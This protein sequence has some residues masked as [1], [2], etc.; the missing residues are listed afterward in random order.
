MLAQD[1][2]EADLADGPAPPSSPREELLAALAA[3]FARSG[4]DFPGAVNLLRPVLMRHGAPHEIVLEHV[5]ALWKE[6]DV[7]AISPVIYLLAHAQFPALAAAA[8]WHALDLGCD[9]DVVLIALADALHMQQRPSQSPLSLLRARFSEQRSVEFHIKLADYY[10]DAGQAF[11]VEELLTFLVSRGQQG[12]ILRL[13]RHWAEFRDWR[14]VRDLLQRVPPTERGDEVLYLLGRACVGLLLEDELDGV[15]AALATASAQG[16]RYAA[17]LRAVWA[18]RLGQYEAAVL[19]PPG[20]GRL[21]P[22]L[23]RDDAALRAVVKTQPVAPSVPVRRWRAVRPEAG[24]PNVLGIGMQRT[25]TSWLWHQLMQHPDVE[26]PIFKEP[27]F[28]TDLFGGVGE[29]GADPSILPMR[30]AERRYWEGPTRNLSR[31]LDLFVGTK[32]VRADISPTYGELPE[33]TVA[34]IRDLLGPDTR[35]LLSVRDPVERSWSNL[36]YDLT[37]TGHGVMSYSLDQ[38]VA[39]YQSAATL[40]RCDYVTVLRLWRRYF[41]HI[42]IVFFDDVAARPADVM[43]EVDAFLGLG[44]RASGDRTLQVNVSGDTK[45]P[46]EDRAFLFGLHQQT[47]REAEA[48]L[49]GAARNWRRRQLRLLDG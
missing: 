44:P 34:V 3:A 43:A 8:G 22:L 5:A 41:N 39:L 10:R 36:K 20:A 28:F 32:P 16:P 18:W 49:G 31:Y 40:R 47:Y 24:L 14:S 7:L 30:D 21:P 42:K 13:A 45:M 17:L 46:R 6:R 38:R 2:V 29:V 12:V 25:A 35:I 26:T 11:L 23:A 48:E 9:N 4:T 1:V 15:L 27:V 33:A 19:G 37:T